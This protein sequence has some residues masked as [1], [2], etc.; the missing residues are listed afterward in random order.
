[1]AQEGSKARGPTFDK[2]LAESLIDL[3]VP[4]GLKFSPNGQKIVYSAGR[5]GNVQNG[6]N[7]V[8]SLWLA[9]AGVPGFAR[10]LTSGSFSDSAA[11]WHPDGNRIFFRSDRAEAGTKYGVWVLRLDGG[12]ATAITPTDVEQNIQE[13]KLSPDGRTVAYLSADEKNEKEKEKNKSD[14]SKADVWGER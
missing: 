5:A 11:T 13:W 9:S 3:E 12:D 8:S 2:E 10:Q 1:M 6:K 14:E 4:K 7:F